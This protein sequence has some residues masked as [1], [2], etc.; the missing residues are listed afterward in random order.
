[1]RSIMILA[2]VPLLAAAPVSAQFKTGGS[3]LGSVLGGGLPDVGGVGAGNAA[4]LI[5]Y[6]VKNKYLSGA[7]ATSVLGKLTGQPG[8]TDSPEYADGQ[9]GLLKS[10]D[11]QFSLS[12]VKGQV[13]TKLCDMVLKQGSSLIGG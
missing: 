6:C 3:G 5:G 11:Q 13:K 2:V 10:G 4:G 12:S 9:N 8:I 7:G 1:M